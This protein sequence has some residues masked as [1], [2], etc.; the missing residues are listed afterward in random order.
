[1]SPRDVYGVNSKVICQTIMKPREV[2]GFSYTIPYKKI[3][4]ENVVSC[5]IFYSVLLI[6]SVTT[7]LHVL[8]IDLSK[9]WSCN[10]PFTIENI[11]QHIFYR[12]TGFSPPE[13]IDQ[14]FLK[15]NWRE[16]PIVVSPGDSRTLRKCV[17][18][19]S[20]MWLMTLLQTSI[21]RKV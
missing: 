7:I 20:C 11:K 2:D 9:K 4:C 3:D 14:I 21:W 18:G 15:L 1:M 5:L 17:G 16:I 19:F 8:L 10:Q 13:L 12:Q 6:S